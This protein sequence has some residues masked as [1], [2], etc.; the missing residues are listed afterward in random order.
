MAVKKRGDPDRTRT[1]DR[2]L[3]LPATAFAAPGR[4]GI[5]GLD[6]LFAISGVPRIVSTEPP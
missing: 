6:Y 4:A 3:S 1:C 5:C 2:L